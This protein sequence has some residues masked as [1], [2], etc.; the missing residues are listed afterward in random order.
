VVYLPSYCRTRGEIYIN[1]HKVSSPGRVIS[2]HKRGLGFIFQVSALWPHMTVEQN[3][4][5]GLNG[6]SKEKV[7]LKV[8]ELLEKISISH[9][10]DRYPDEISGGEARRAALARSLAPEPLCMLMDEPLTNL[11]AEL[12]NNLLDFTLKT[13]KESNTSLIYVTHDMKEGES[14]S[15]NKLILTGG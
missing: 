3:I 14:V 2:P 6:L 13:L 9:L 11:D 8:E 5:F 12:K 4:R 1:G 7:K 10:K 15:K